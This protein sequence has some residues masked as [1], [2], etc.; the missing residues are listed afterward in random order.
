MSYDCPYAE[1]YIARAST[2]GMHTHS[3]PQLVPSGCYCPHK[4]GY[5]H[6]TVPRG[7]APSLA[8]FRTCSRCACCEC[9][10][11]L[12]S[13]RTCRHRQLPTAG[14]GVKQQCSSPS[15]GQSMRALEPK[16]RPTS[17]HLGT[18]QTSAPSMELG[19]S[20]L[21]MVCVRMVAY[22]GAPWSYIH[23]SLC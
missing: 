17:T 8:S 2:R 3:M 23:L 19:K 5:S 12:T 6:D 10:H 9:A 4:A 11:R 14:D 22:A 18:M 15:P 1:S 13:F 21:L 16:L 7:D 20:A